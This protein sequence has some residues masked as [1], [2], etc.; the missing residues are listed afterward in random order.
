[1][2]Y[3]PRPAC[4]LPLA[5]Q[6]HRHGKSLGGEVTAQ[7]INLPPRPSI[8]PRH[9][10]TTHTHRDTHTLALFH[11]KRPPHFTLTGEAQMSC[12]KRVMAVSAPEI[13]VHVRQC[14]CSFFF[15]LVGTFSK[16]KSDPTSRLQQLLLLSKKSTFVLLCQLF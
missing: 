7:S 10:P 15:V 13:S 8:S 16:F 3:A 12:P 6:Q 14:L 2:K 1:M 4:L 5:R 11:C 9:L